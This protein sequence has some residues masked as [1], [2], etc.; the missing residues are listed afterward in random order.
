MSRTDFAPWQRRVYEQ[1]VAALDSGRMG[2]A[3]LLCG[4][5]G[6][7]KR[8]V[9]EALAQY[10]LCQARAGGEPCGRCRSCQLF[11][12]RAQRDPVETRPDGSLAQPHGHSAHPD[13][14]FVGYEW[15][16]KPAPPRMRTEI[17]IEQMRQLSERLEVSAGFESRIALVDPADAVNYQAWNAIL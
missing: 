12:V 3:L 14:V 10:V 4:P 13:L 5:A 6:L 8:A 1:A 16:L 15:R 9:A 7:G 2:H 17:V 11:G